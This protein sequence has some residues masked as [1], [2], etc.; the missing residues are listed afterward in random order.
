MSKLHDKCQTRPLNLVYVILKS[1]KNA[2]SLPISMQKLLDVISLLTKFMVKFAKTWP[3]NDF[4]C[5]IG[6]MRCF[7]QT[8]KSYFRT[9]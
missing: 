3:N 8:I 4:L 5:E 6:V 1:Y 7:S 9:N 2:L